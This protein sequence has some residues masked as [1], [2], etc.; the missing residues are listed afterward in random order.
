MAEGATSSIVDPINEILDIFGG[1]QTLRGQIHEIC[2]VIW[3][4]IR[5][6]S[7]DMLL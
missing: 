6:E 5:T 7:L 1:S 3:Q 2:V 4:S